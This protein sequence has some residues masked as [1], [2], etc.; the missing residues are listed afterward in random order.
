M[1]GLLPALLCLLLLSLP[2]RSS[3]SEDDGTVVIT[4]SGPIQGKRLPAGSNT[5]TAFLGIPYAEPPVGALRFQK[6]LPHKPWNRVLEATSFGKA[7]HQL[8][9]TDYPDAEMFSVK[10]PQSEDCLFLNVW[11]P[12]PRP[13]GPIPVLVWIHGGGFYMGATSVELHNGRFLATGGKVIVASMNYRLGP[14]GFLSLPPA[15]PGNAGLWDQRLALRWVW[16]NAAAFGGDPARLM[17]FGQS[18]GAA[19]VGLHLLSPRSRP[20]FTRAVLQS[21]APNGPWAWTSLE[22]AKKRGQTLG[23]LLG[24]T[25]GGNNTALVGCL[26]GKEP[27]EITKFEFSV[28]QYP[29]LMAIP[30]LPTPDGDFLPDAPPRLLKARHGP[31][32]PILTGFTANE[33]SYLLSG[34]ATGFNLENASS[35]GWEE[36]LRVVRLMVPGA[37]EEAVQAVARR[38]SREGEG[39]GEAQYRWAMEQFLGDYS[40]VCPVAEVAGQEAEAGNPVYAYYFTHRS[41]S[42]SS[43]AWTG[44]PHSSDLLFTLGTLVSVGGTNHAPTEAEVGLSRKVMRYWVEFARSGNPT[45]TEDSGVLWPPYDR[46]KQN[47]FRIGMAPHQVQDPSPA[48]HCSFLAS[49]LRGQRSTPGAKPRRVGRQKRS[50]K[51]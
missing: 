30:F 9:L 39:Q 17:L 28:L 37:P 41:S 31:P 2:G 13:P 51:S 23:R 14:L 20:F 19:A 36:L 44:V 33:G 42:L 24:C 48:R 35:I 22:E 4:T 12:H 27:G 8:Q 21:G 1:P 40:I 38:Y 45:G 15:A 29:D 3:G 49:L 47:F 25:D 34:G 5:V 6:P 16:K 43:P 7:C 10:M 26:Q 46:K 50:M 32:I 11:V 18:A